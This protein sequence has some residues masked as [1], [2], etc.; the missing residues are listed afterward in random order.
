VAARKPRAGGE[1]FRPSVFACTFPACP[2]SGAEFQAQLVRRMTAEE[3]LRRSQALRDSAWE[4]K[5]A[6]IRVSRPDL[7]ERAVQKIVRRIFRDAGA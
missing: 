6:W 5:A 3:K 7:G 1:S 4:L 2:L